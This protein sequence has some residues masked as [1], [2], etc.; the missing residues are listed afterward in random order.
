MLS[1][2]LL[3]PKLTPAE[4]QEWM[5]GAPAGEVMTVLGRFRELS[6]LAEGAQKSNVAPV[7]D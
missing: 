1:L 4:V 2:A 6:G 3:D 5:K 7:R